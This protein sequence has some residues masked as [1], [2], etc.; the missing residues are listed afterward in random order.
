[1]QQKFTTK[2]CLHNT[3]RLNRQIYQQNKW[4]KLQKL[5]TAL[6]VVLLILSAGCGYHLKTKSDQSSLTVSVPYFEGDGDGRITAQV[7]EVIASE[8]PFRYVTGK[9]DYILCGKITHNDTSQ[10]GYK[11]DRTPDG[12]LENRLVPDEGR[13]NIVVDFT[14]KK[15]DETILGPITVSGSGNFDFVNPDT[16]NDLSFTNASGTT[17]SVL[18]FSLGQLDAKEGASDAALNVAYAEIASKIARAMCNIKP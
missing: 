2:P 6:L 7:V 14:L 1:M 18:T 16:I 10:I 4:Q 8:T 5:K 13:R 15:N 3:H 17:Q 9:G 12:V 11:Y